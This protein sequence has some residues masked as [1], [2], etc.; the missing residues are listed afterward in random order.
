MVFINAADKRRA[1]E[2]L[3]PDFP[4]IR[5]DKV[6]LVTPSDRAVSVTVKFKVPIYNSFN[7]LPGCGGLNIDTFGLIMATPTGIEPVSSL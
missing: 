3:I 2:A 1:I 6:F 7:I 4:L 5:K